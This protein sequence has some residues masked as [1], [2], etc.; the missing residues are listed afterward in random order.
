MTS[1]QIVRQLLALLIGL[2]L[3]LANAFSAD[4]V[5][6]ASQVEKEPVSLSE[7]FAV[8]ED[9]GATLTLE[10]VQRPDVAARFKHDQA[11]AAA[12]SY[13]ITRSAY[14]FRLQMR[15]TS[16]RPIDRMLEIS[17][18]LLSNVQFHQPLFDGTSS[19]AYQSLETGNALYFSTRAHDGRFFVFPVTLA[20]RTEGVYYFRAQSAHAVLFPARIWEPKAFQTYERSDYFAQA[21]YFGM[22][23][24]MVLFNLLLFFA[25]RDVI[26]LQYVV[27][28]SFMAFALAARNGLAQEFL[29][30][31]MPLFSELSFY[32]GASFSLVG[33]L[34]FTRRM[35]QTRRLL[36]AS[37][38][39][40]RF[41]IVV[42]LLTPIALA[43]DLQ[44]SLKPFIYLILVTTGFI[45]AV[46][47]FCAYK[48]ERSAYFFIAAFSMLVLGA[49]MTALRALGYLPTNVFTVNGLQFGSALEMILLAFSLAD[50]FNQ[51]RREKANDQ[52]ALLN[53]QRNL[54]ESLQSSEQLLEQK[55]QERTH[56]LLEA[57]QQLESR[58]NEL[59]DTNKE[60]ARL[61]V[62]DRLTGLYNRLRLDSALEDELRR[63][64]RYSSCFSLVLLDIDHFKSINDT[65]GH[66]VGDQVLVT[67]ARLLDEGTRDADVVGRW[68]G[69]EFLIICPDTTLEGAIA[70]AEKL[71]NL[72]AGH[73]FSTVGHKTASFGVATVR[74]ND[75]ASTLMAR[76]D[77]ALYRGKTNGRNRVEAAT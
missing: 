56:Q 35:L 28:V 47:G 22:A 29:W 50:R 39:P 53:A 70:S 3:L 6:V 5:L 17:Y 2:G 73:N 34:L 1:R 37:E 27:F 15:N 55:V 32:A 25:L 19:G 9:P 41:L 60:L 7:Y 10:D 23:T 24:A 74:K 43:I 36:P 76:V 46:G 12:L 11:P 68:G 14:W 54:L 20:A 58:T 30:F 16:D 44:S 4:K 71:R 33:L 57:N 63:S 21:W 66:S 62:T 75:T 18:S 59:H 72:V 61:S 51:I 69:E 49:A 64:Q 26:Y 38:P 65:F 48:R 42:Y 8:L 77:E 40:L 13:G 67:V 52:M 31:D 45:A